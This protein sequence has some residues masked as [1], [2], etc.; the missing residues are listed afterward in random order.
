VSAH[1][2]ARALSLDFPDVPDDGPV[3]APP[4]AQVKPPRVWQRQD[5]A[6]SHLHPCTDCQAAAARI[7]ARVVGEFAP[8]SMPE[9]EGH[10]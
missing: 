1:R 4:P 2:I 9:F 6:C 10:R 8:G 3:A 5:G 7:L